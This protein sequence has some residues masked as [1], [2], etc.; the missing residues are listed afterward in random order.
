METLMLILMV[1]LVV[2]VVFA[3]VTYVY[4]WC[5]I[6]IILWEETSNLR[7]YVMCWLRRDAGQKDLDAC[8]AASKAMGGRHGGAA[9]YSR[10]REGE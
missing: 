8:L 9:N 1:L 4:T 10:E 3:A 2:L 7:Y 5:I 6:L